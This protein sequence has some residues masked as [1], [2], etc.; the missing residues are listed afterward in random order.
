MSSSSL[1]STKLAKN[2]PTVVPMREA[3]TVP[4]KMSAAEIP[5]RKAK[6]VAVSIRNMSRQYTPIVRRPLPIGAHCS[7]K[8]ASAT[9]PSAIAGAIG[10]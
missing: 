9:M 3:T 5:V 10:S 6:S 2:V 7:G 1:P 4:P 8:M